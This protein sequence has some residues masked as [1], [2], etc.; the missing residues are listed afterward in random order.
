MK[1]SVNPGSISRFVVGGTGSEYGL[2]VAVIRINYYR[3]IMT[4]MKFHMCLAS[5]SRCTIQINMLQEL[6]DVLLLR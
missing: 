6:F 3:R 4:D 1:Y 2:P 5:L